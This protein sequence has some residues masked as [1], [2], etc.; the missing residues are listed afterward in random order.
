M[1]ESNMLVIVG[2]EAAVLLLV[3]CV[4][5]LVYVRGLRR[6][7]TALE[8]K[9][10]GLRQTVKSVRIE[11]VAA[12]RELVE[13]HKAQLDATH[14]YGRLLDEQLDATRDRHRQLHPEQSLNIDESAA[15]PMVRRPLALRHAFLGAERAAWSDKTNAVD[16][17]LLGE[18]FG[19]IIRF[20]EQNALA[21]LID[22]GVPTDDPQ[23]LKAVAANQRRHIEMLEQRWRETESTARRYQEALARGALDGDEFAALLERY[24]N[25]WLDFGAELGKPLEVKRS[26]EAGPEAAPSIGRAVI[27]NQEE[28][29]RL[30]NM[31]VDQHK[32]I[33]QLKQQLERAQS[34]EEKDALIAGLRQQLEHHERFL[35]ESELCSRQLEAELERV[36][37]E[38]QEL[39]QHPV[40][41]SGD[42]E[43]A[44]L[45]RMVGDFT[46]QSCDMLSAIDTLE[47]E[48]ARL[49]APRADQDS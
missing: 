45:T 16:W 34:V 6:L 39:R 1:F 23:A 28:V 24:A 36:L 20:C 4:A 49:R 7:V 15:V 48:N 11:A 13:L 30:R 9:V 19:R 2:V 46:R 27:A 8:A 40:S 12:R 44:R 42:E 21:E 5:L 32:M 22:D 14:D 37:G 10:T 31:A 18:Q 35:R 29:I 38:N 17:E 43:L 26:A 47:K 33:V 25:V 41:G 3:L